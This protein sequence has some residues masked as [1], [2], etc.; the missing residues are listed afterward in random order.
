ML[1]VPGPGRP[2]DQQIQQEQPPVSSYKAHCRVVL[3]GRADHQPGRRGIGPARSGPELN[4]TPFLRI[5]VTTKMFPRPPRPAPAPCAAAP[6]GGGHKRRAGKVM[7]GGMRGKGREGQGIPAAPLAARALMPLPLLPQLPAAGPARAPH[8]AP[9]PLLPSTSRPSSQRALGALVRVT[10][11]G[12]PLGPH[13]RRRRTRVWPPSRRRPSSC[14]FCH[15]TWHQ[16]GGRPT[17][18]PGLR[19]TA[20]NSGGLAGPVRFGPV[21]VRPL[22]GGP[23]FI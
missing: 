10:A 11:A 15:P 20:E 4:P 16:A 1:G 8:T 3:Q 12:P 17:Q 19:L 6:W 18:P 21:R 5:T 22:P 14:P 9:Q 2:P 7:G 23:D 13:L